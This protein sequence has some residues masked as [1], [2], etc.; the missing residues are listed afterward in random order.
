M[1][2]VISLAAAAACVSV[3]AAP[4]GAL[5]STG[6][7]YGYG[8]RASALGNTMLGGIGDPFATFYNPAANSTHPGLQVSLG[9]DFAHPS[10]TSINNIIVNNSTI[11]SKGTD[12]RGDV[13]TTNYQDQLGQMVGASFNFGE[14]FKSLTA[15]VTAFLPLSRVAYLDT[16]DPYLPEYVS[17]RS[18]TQRPQIYGSLSASPLAHLHLAMGVALSTNLSASTNAYI[19]SSSTSV[20]HQQFAST[21][22]P[23]VAPYFSAYADPDPVAVGVT[24]RMPNKYTISV[25]TN[26]D[27]G[28]LAN[29]ASL[30]LVLNS[31]STI[32][33]DP[34]EAD[35]AAATKLTQN[36]W[37]TLEVDWFQYKAFE[38][39]ILTV[40]NIASA[41]NIHNSINS[42]PT[43]KNI[44]VPKGG[45]EIRGESVT[46]RLGYMYRPS[47]I[48]STSGAGNLVDPSRHSITAGIGLNLKTMKVVEKDI[49]LDLNAQYHLLV[50]QHIEKSSGNELGGAG[51]KVGSPG[52]D[53]GGSI[54]G[55]GFSLTMAF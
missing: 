36:L 11:S 43:F 20:S 27:A 53:I 29:T 46:Y 34:L 30:P 51:N 40:T 35:I 1:R 33:Y 39:P 5:A 2:S 52:Y 47:P 32:F 3:F 13:D 14:K 23:G 49:I 31:S 6:E 54:Y 48:E 45:L 10:F 42:A 50:K 15:G 4:L 26:A 37:A 12:I 28:L 22:K 18:R 7:L 21:I 9:V 24:I 55:G 25:D 8:S 44:F 16:S 38:S 17:Y 41:S 19:T